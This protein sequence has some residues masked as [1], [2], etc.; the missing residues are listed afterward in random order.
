MIDLSGKWHIIG[1]LRDGWDGLGAKAPSSELMLKLAGLA[2]RL[3]EPNFRVEM[4]PTRDGGLVWEF[5]RDAYATHIN[6]I[7]HRYYY[8][9]EFLPNGKDIVATTE[10]DYTTPRDSFF[11]Y[12]EFEG[13]WPRFIQVPYPPKEFPY[14]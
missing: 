13:F 2:D 12:E 1:R 11:T 5:E 10:S 7:K 4:G 14:A 9:I 6:H 8:T 3:D